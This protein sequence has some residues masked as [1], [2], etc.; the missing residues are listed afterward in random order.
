MLG[1]SDMF[2]GNRC[3]KCG[4]V[5]DCETVHNGVALLYGPAFC[6]SC[7]WTEWEDAGKVIDGYLHD[8]AGGATPISDARAVVLGLPIVNTKAA[9]TEVGADDWDGLASL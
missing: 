3:P 6:T 8:R 2:D 5:A 4:A 9:A 7:P 1:D